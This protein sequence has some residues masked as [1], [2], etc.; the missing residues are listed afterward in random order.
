MHKNG[1]NP[2]DPFPRDRDVA[3]LWTCYGEN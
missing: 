2:L 3:N 1:Q